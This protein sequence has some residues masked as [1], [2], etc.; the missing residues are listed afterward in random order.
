MN[1]TPMQTEQRPDAV[2]WV[3]E[4]HAI[5]AERDRAGGISTVEVRRLQQSEPRYLGHI[6]HE[7]DGHERVMIVG[8]QP[9]RL[10]LERRF[11]SVTHRPDRLMAT[12]PA[13]R[14]EGSKM[15]EGV[16]RLAA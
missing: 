10:A 15:V 7:L 3:D 9:L 4:R 1:V 13:A 14:V 11:V 8:A 5:V 2:V 12:A 16:A 6:V